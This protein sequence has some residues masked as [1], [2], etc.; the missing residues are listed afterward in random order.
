MS[1][2]LEQ[3]PLGKTS[4]YVDTYTATLL[5][6]LPRQTQRESIHIESPCPF[7]GFDLW[8]A[9]EVS[10]L[11]DKGKP[12][13]A[14]AQW[15]VPCDSANL[16][17]SKSLKLYLNSFN[18]TAFT[19]AEQVQ[20]TLSQDLS[21]CAGAPVAVVLLNPTDCLQ[22]MS[23]DW[24]GICLDDED[25]ACDT[26]HV[27]PELLSVD[28]GER[29]SEVLYSHCLKSNCPVTGQ[30]D[31]GSIR[32]EYSGQPINHAGLLQYIVSYRQHNEFHEHCVER[33]FMD[34]L[35]QCQPEQLT[36]YARYTRRGGLD[37]NPIRSTEP[38]SKVDNQ[39][40]FRQ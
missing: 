32:I 29:V 26:Y 27:N 1:H 3:T 24:D 25:I 19:S 15:Q 40:L 5:F 35:R 34:I 16:I 12:L 4:T 10:W 22:Q 8:N 11:N 36:V 6:P 33:I 31:W 21:A 13:V 30:P 37:I 2:S 18:Q 7:Y 9:Y 20:Q 14:C 23:G 28:K 38:M 39:R 17:E